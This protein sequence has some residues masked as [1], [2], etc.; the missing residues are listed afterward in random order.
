[1]IMTRID[2]SLRQ[3]HLRQWRDLERVLETG[4]LAAAVDERQRVGERRQQRRSA[5]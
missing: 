5:A 3:R 4:P 2:L 1:M